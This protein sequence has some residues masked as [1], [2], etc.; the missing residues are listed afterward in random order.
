MSAEDD[1]FRAWH[2]AIIADATE[3]VG[4]SLTEAK[5]TFITKRRGF[6]GL[7]AIHDTVRFSTAED[8][9]AYLNLESMK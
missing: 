5:R 1:T 4:R 3:K 8:V 2:E 6:I 9:A 7:E